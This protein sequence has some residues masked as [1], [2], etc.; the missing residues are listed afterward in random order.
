MF[1]IPPTDEPRE[2]AAQVLFSVDRFVRNHKAKDFW[3]FSD[4]MEI[5]ETKHLL[6]PYADKQKRSIEERA[7]SRAIR[8]GGLITVGPEIVWLKDD[9]IRNN[10]D[11]TTLICLV[12]PAPSQTQR[13]TATSSHE[14]PTTRQTPNSHVGKGDLRGSMI[15]WVGEGFA[16]ATAAVSEGQGTQLAPVKVPV[17]CV[18]QIDEHE[19]LHVRPGGE[20]V[21]MILFGHNHEAWE[22][23]SE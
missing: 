2:L 6:R 1:I 17:G 22:T 10:L 9:L 13:Q 5:N 8:L 19:E 7:M 16:D 15:D 4:G 14:G 18:L 12:I 11:K 21:C 23:G 3:S 20:G